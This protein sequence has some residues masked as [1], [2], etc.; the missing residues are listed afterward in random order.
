VQVGERSEKG[1]SRQ[2]N[3]DRSMVDRLQGSGEVCLLAVA[4]GMGGHRSGEIAAEVAISTMK[5]TLKGAAESGALYSSPEKALSQAFADANRDV[6]LESDRTQ[7]C[8]GMG[9]TLTAALVW[10]GRLTVGHVGDT[11]ALLFKDR[12]LSAL[13][14]DHSLV[15]ELL[16]KNDLSEDEAMRHPQR[17]MLTR[18]LGLDEALQV[19]ILDRDLEGGFTVIIAS[20][21]VTGLLKTK[22]L[23]GLVLQDYSSAQELADRIVEAAIVRGGHDDATCVVG[24]FE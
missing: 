14:V 20:D 19:D 10:D 16:R 7:A 9:T 15:G 13:T 11:R 4:D 22:E 17:N 6:F 1:I 2:I 23:E 8:R 5:E 21:G 18:A 3:Q 24:I 12:H